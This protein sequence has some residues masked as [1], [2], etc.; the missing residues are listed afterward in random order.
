MCY[1]HLFTIGDAA[2]IAVEAEKLSDL[3]EAS[4][5]MT[6]AKKA[7]KDKIAEAENISVMVHA[8]LKEE[9]LDTLASRIASKED[10]ESEHSSR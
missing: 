5:K 4:T 8:V 6:E 2:A 1:F 7:T 10:D 9:H 3:K